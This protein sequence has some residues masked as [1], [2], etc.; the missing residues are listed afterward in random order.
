MNKKKARQYLEMIAEDGES[1]RYYDPRNFA[2][3]H[4]CT[5]TVRPCPKKHTQSVTQTEFAFPGDEERRKAEYQKWLED[6]KA[7]AMKQTN[8]EV[9]SDAMKRYANN[10]DVSKILS[11]AANE[12]FKKSAKSYLGGFGERL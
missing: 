2:P 4:K 9:L 10:P 5:A 3:E 8:H 1:Y 12:L 11:D 7:W 6:Y